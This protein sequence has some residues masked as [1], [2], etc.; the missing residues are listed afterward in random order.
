MNVIRDSLTK[1]M[2]RQ[3]EDVKKDAF[4]KIEKLKALLNRP[5]EGH[6]RMKR[7]L[8]EATQK[9]GG[10]EASLIKYQNKEH[11][12]NET[13]K[14]FK[15]NQKR[16]QENLE[17]LFDFIQT[18]EKYGVRIEDSFKDKIRN[19]IGNIADQKLKVA[20]VGGFSDGKTTI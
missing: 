2:E 6:E 5:V 9:L 19:A 14:Q 4:E 10:I 3:L 7:Q 12:M 16:N 1:S 18:G 13:L 15:A 8:E 20:L 11:T 17:K